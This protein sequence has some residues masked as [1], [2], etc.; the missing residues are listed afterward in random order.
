MRMLFA[1]PL[2]VVSL[3]GMKVSHGASLPLPFAEPASCITCTGCIGGRHQAPLDPEGANSAGHPCIIALCAHPRCGAAMV[4]ILEADSTNLDHRRDLLLT[5]AH[6][7]VEAARLV[8]QDYP[9]A[10]VYN[11][12]RQSLQIRGCRDGV[13]TGNIPLTD[14]QAAIVAP[15][16]ATR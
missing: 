2:L 14:Q 5:V 16:Y 8:M 1:V 13:V 7:D 12:A 10:F 9:E 4:D 6:G 15:T 3:V 11:R